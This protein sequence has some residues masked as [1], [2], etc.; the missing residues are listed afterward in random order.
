VAWV[1]GAS[2][3]IGRGIA[4]ASGRVGWVVHS[5]A[6]AQRPYFKRK[7]GR[8]ALWGGP[9]P[10]LDVHPLT[11]RQW[12]FLRQVGLLGLLPD[13]RGDP[14]FR[15]HGR[16]RNA[17]VAELAITTGMRLREFSTL[18]DIEVGPPRRDGSPG[19]V[20]LEATAKYGL[21]RTVR[22]L[23]PV[24]RQIDLYRRTE[25]AAA[26]R[27]AAPTLE[28]HRA[29]LFVVGEV[30]ARRMRVT[31]RLDGRVRT[32]DIARMD[33]ALRRRAVIEGAF[34]LEPMGLFV[35]RGGRMLGRSRGQVF[36]AAHRR[37]LRLAAAD[38]LGFEMPQRFRIHDMRHTIAI[39]AAQQP[40][41]EIALG[42]QLKHAARRALANRTTQAYYAAD[43]SWAGQFDTQYELAAAAR[44]VDALR[45]RQAG[46]VV[47]FGP[48]AA[49]FHDRLDRVARQ[50][51]A[52]P[53][54]RA[55]V[56]DHAVLT[57]LLREQF[58]DLHWGTLNHCLWNPA[59]AEC[60]TPLPESQRG[61]KPLL[62]AC[63]PGK[64]RNS[65]I[66]DTHMPVWLAQ[67][68]DL[69][70]MLTDLRMAPPRSASLRSRL[71]EVEQI[72]SAWRRARGKPEE[73]G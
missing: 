47:A 45:Q 53:A 38:D 23:H 41:G 34:G 27:R 13:G 58:P 8:D 33:A 20:R 43:A 49:I 57:A 55:Q 68:Q 7:S 24:L 21:A 26:I 1:T 14:A 19:E 30:D 69:R 72:T 60:Q 15:G 29:E 67:E 32:F 9:V 18:L 35:G 37:S 71:G 73:E 64:C 12:R 59:V 6:L 51:T 4:L 22:I 54:L 36:D 28:R 16:L 46:Q 50:L 66:T 63:Q 2:R 5:G 40:D 11:Y 61:G 17:A 56:G 39:I 25:R 31:G 52:D 42:M 62:G 10:Q 70:T 3:G 44:L 48:G 65:T